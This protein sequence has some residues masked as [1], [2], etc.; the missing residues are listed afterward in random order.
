MSVG[1][2]GMGVVFGQPW[3]LLALLAIPAILVLH[4]LRRR[5]RPTPVS[6][7]FLFGEVT[8]SPA[9][10]RRRERLR[11]TPS[12]WLELLAA[13]AATFWLADPHTDTR[14]AAHH[15]VV[16]LD[17][18][19]RLD[20]RA[21]DG[22]SARDRAAAALET[23]MD[24]LGAGDRVTLVLSGAPPRL[25]AGPAARPDQARAALSG[26][27]ADAPWHPL[28]DAL[29]LALDLARG[30]QGD[31]APA[32]GVVLLATDHVPARLP[33][34]VGLVAAG[35]PLP[36]SGL[37][38]VR[39]L[40]ASAQHPERLVVRAAAFG[41]PRARTLLVQAPDGREVARRP[42]TLSP[43]QPA[44]AV[45]A[46]A[47]PGAASDLAG[48]T[49]RLEGDDPLAFDDA[50]PLL[51]PPPRQ[52][53]VHLAPGLPG[54]A[55]VR[56]IAQAV[57]DVRLTSAAEA[58]LI[59][60]G[61]GAEA[62]APG[63]WTLAV[64]PGPA[65]PVLGPY[66]ATRGH[67]VLADLDFTGCVWAGGLP[68]AQVPAGEELLLAAGDAVLLTQ[69]R[70]G[71]ALHLTLHL[72][73]QRSLLTEHPALPALFAN[74][75]AARRD[76]LPGPTR[77][78]L[79]LG[80]PTTLGLPFGADVLQLTPPDGPPVVLQA[81]PQGRVLL[82]GLSRPGLHTLRAVGPLAP[83]DASWRVQG[84]LLD[85]RLA[86]LSEAATETR[87][88]AT[89]ARARVERR[90]G[91]LGHLLPLVALAL[92]ALAAVRAHAREGG[93]APRPAHAVREA[94]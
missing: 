27:R 58:D 35:Q 59:V 63:I 23:R 40:P 77:V 49:V 3:G 62:P 16:V 24:A 36:A 11:R 78:N 34:S 88:P 54:E 50:A 5:F 4:L 37:A 75:L 55:V 12:L 15:V 33:D 38:D 39:W 84:L 71:R 44:H 26:W 18:R 90:R 43:D 74:L 86:D 76:A 2:V 70:A 30:G 31:D 72:D 13:L 57:G 8:P 28:D 20:A 89:A 32:Q 45:V 41:A 81:D 14:E 21:P 79:P 87:E 25:L 1:A 82:Q 47:A 69:R 52:V 85:P 83:A 17:T 46:L 73:L 48:L 51:P 64:T 80:Q 66:L 22:R 60:G 94:A 67:P 68:A 65:P 19:A 9:S 10:G 29:T 7:L 93:A 92:L 56:R 6:G 61:P 53:R 42:L 91:P